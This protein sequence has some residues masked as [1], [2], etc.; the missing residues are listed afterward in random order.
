MNEEKKL[1][2]I[3]SID[4]IMKKLADRS[5][6]GLYSYPNLKKELIA[7]RLRYIYKD[8]S[9]EQFV[10]DNQFIEEWKSVLQI[11]NI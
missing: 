6:V 5:S 9:S 7:M 3:W 10:S 2:V 11:C 8:I 1:K 4:T